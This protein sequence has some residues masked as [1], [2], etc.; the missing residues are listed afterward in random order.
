MAGGS[1]VLDV[2]V[3]GAIGIRNQA[4]AIADAVSIDRIWNKAIAR[5]AHGER[6]EGIVWRQL[7]CWEVHNVVVLAGEVLIGTVYSRQPV[8]SLFRDVDG[9]GE[10]N[11][12][13]GAQERAIAR[14]TASEDGSPP[15]NPGDVSVRDEMESDKCQRKADE[16]ALYG[17]CEDIPWTQGRE[18]TARAF[19]IG[20]ILFTS[21]GRSLKGSLID[22]S[23]S[24]H[25]LR[26][27]QA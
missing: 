9:A 21:D 25:P 12:T 22:H 14:L 8:H 7:A 6:P 19:C 2:N 24:I 18:Q 27:Y 10:F 23:C 4:G 15:I 11:G 13:C 26:I 16:E 17:V 20:Q 3:D 5:G 1:G